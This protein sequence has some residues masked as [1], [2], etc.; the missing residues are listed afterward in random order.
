[1]VNNGQKANETT[2]ND[3]FL[4]RTDDSDTVGVVG[5]NNTTDVNSGAAVVNTQRAIN[6]LFDSDGT[7]GEADANAK[8]Y[9]SNNIVV[10]GDSRKVAI[11]RLDQ[12]VG[13]K[14]DHP[15]S[16]TVNGVAKFT[17]AGG[18]VIESSGV[19]IDSSDN[20]EIP[21]DLIVQG[22]LTVNGTTTTVNSA[23]LEVTDSNITI[24]NGGND[25]SAEGSGITI[26][27][28]TTNGSLVFDS[29]V[30]SFWKAGTAGSEVELVTV[31][32]GQILTNKTIDGD[33][34]TIQDLGITSLKTDAGNAT[35]FLSFDGSGVP[36]TTKVVPTGVVV[37]TTDTQTLA[38]KT[39]DGDNNTVQ[40]LPITS[41]KTNAGN[42][43]KFLSFNGS[44]APIATK[45]V[46]TG[47]VVGDADIQTLTN[48]TI[49]GD[50]NT[51][52]DLPIT[53]IKTVIGNATKFLSFDGSG[54]P[55]ATKDVPTGVV[56]G[57]ADTQTLTNK[58][59]TS[60][61]INDALAN[62]EY[63]SEAAAPS[64]P[65]SGQV[66][67]Y[68]KTDG[69][70]YSKDDAGAESAL[71]GGGGGGGANTSLSN[72]VSPTALNEDLIFNTGGAST[73][74]T[75]NDNAADTRNLTIR[76]GNGTGFRSG[77]LFLQSG[78]ADTN[79][80]GTVNIVTGTPAVNIPSGSVSVVTGPTTGTGSSGD[81]NV[82][83]GSA[84]STGNSGNLTLNSGGVDSGS[85][86]GISLY[87]G[88][89][90]GSAGNSGGIQI[91]TGDSVD[92]NSGDI[93]AT[94]GGTSGTG[95]TGN[96][97]LQTGNAVVGDS[98][99]VS[100][101]VGT[102]GGTQ[103]SIIFQKTGVANSV[104]D[105]W[106]ATNTAG[107]GY[108]AAPASAPTNE[109]ETFTLAGGDIT[110]QYIDLANVALVDSITF[111]VKGGV[112]TLEGAAHD[113]SVSYTGGAGGNTRITFLNDLA[114]GGPA[115]LIAG[116]IIQVKYQF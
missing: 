81:I 77:D 89:S 23:T 65:P 12:A 70:L 42:A 39:I 59:L 28:T 79:Q 62:A 54:V 111:I 98:G 31:S 115:A 19:T 33:D 46:P 1:M 47:V 104:G 34:N 92:S 69:L 13:L 87:T 56:V 105:V 24:N 75:V 83:S 40:D 11:E 15:L 109:K 99:S 102:A 94:S 95:A 86:G 64:T 35:K 97:I 57:D 108:W 112:P 88:A 60:P 7:T 25:A 82:N 80:T 45:V 14:L 27:R 37:G 72:L 116:D 9:S 30:N 110:N 41:L 90:S 100:L 67:L 29:G 58:T 74:Q 91:F 36:V 4:S 103:G 84:T 106:T 51:V 17:D 20:M 8:N 78:T 52:Q 10:D 43:T 71:S 5:L 85:S 55:V 26:E 76:T 93:L 18:E 63:F 3:A 6:K 96:A 101:R 38:N 66:V 114:T 2:F 48:K 44:G 50:D 53:S 68:A 73:I 61:S 49:D 107:E 113:Y 32:E 22:D 21:G 16:S